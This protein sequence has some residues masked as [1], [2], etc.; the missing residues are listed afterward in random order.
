M[1]FMYQDWSDDLRMAERHFLAGIRSDAWLKIVVRL[2]R[3]E[4]K[5]DV[6]TGNPGNEEEHIYL[7]NL[8]YE[9]KLAVR[10]FRY[11]SSEQLFGLLLSGQHQMP[12]IRFN[13][14]LKYDKLNAAY[15]AIAQRKVPKGYEKIYG[16]TC[17]FE[18]WLLAKLAGGSQEP[19]CGSLVD[20]LVQEAAFV[21]DRSFV[22]AIKHGRARLGNSAT[23]VGVEVEIDGLWVQIFPA[24]EVIWIEEWRETSSDG[25]TEYRHSISC[26]SFDFREEVGVLYVTEKIVRAIIT[27]RIETL[28]MLKNNKSQM[29]VRFEVPKN[30]IVSNN[31]IRYK[32]FP[33]RSQ[34]PDAT[35]EERQ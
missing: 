31:I 2:A 3:T 26:E 28:D 29:A 27:W 25:L 10:L 33:P 4:Q 9:D 18:E 8:S 22:N 7:G 34:P 32:G 13:Q 14:S 24:K 35:S 23:A 6:R 17:N 19:L 30:I 11:L 12:L 20:F 5:T 1:A 15:A 16:R 21:A